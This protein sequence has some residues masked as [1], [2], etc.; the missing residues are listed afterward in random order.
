MSKLL[1][2]IRRLESLKALGFPSS[3]HEV[4][5]FFTVPYDASEAEKKAAYELQHPGENYEDV[6]FVEVKT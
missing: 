3:P 5:G 1:E 6:T 2:R 4:I